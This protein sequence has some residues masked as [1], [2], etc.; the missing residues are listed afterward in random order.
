MIRQAIPF[1]ANIVLVAQSDGTLSPSKLEKLDAIRSD[2]KFKKSDLTG[3]IKLVESGNHKMIP[4]GSFVDQVKNLELILSV[5]YTDETINE[6]ERVLINE[7]MHAAGIYEEQLERIRQEVLES[8]SN[9][10]KSCPS[11]GALSD[12]DARFCPKCGKNLDDLIAEDA[13][14]SG[15]EIPRTGLAI[16]FAESTA[17]SFPKALEIARVSSGFQSCQ[18]NK[19]YWYLATYPSNALIDAIP[20]SRAL[21]GIRNRLLHLDG[22]ETPW[23]EVFG[24]AWCAERRETAYRPIEYCFGKDENRLNP[25]GCKQANM[26]WS[27]WAKWFCYGRWEK[28]GMFGGKV[29][30]R[31]DKERIRH[32]LS[33]NLFRFRFCPHLRTDLADAILKYLP[34]TITPETDRNWGF[35]KSFDETPGAVKV[36]EKE[37]AGG[38]TY[39]NEYWADGVSPKGLQAFNDILTKA[40]R[41]LSGLQVSV[42]NLLK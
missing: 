42:S 29:K 20:L 2:L 5:A 40:A 34:E 25:W 14:P 41:E 38:F 21:S 30:W 8:I 4:V 10:G 3:A 11:C 7:F 19:K 17:A 24:F 22:K 31:F 6:K 27:D 13:G 15:Y 12:L 28:A 18:K 33:T 35:H 26:D 37:D 36:V 16:E 23:D 39:K 9:Q 32:E 1:L